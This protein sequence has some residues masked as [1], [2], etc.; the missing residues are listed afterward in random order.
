MAQTDCTWH[1]LCF[2]FQDGVYGVMAWRYADALFQWAWCGPEEVRLAPAPD[3]EFCDVWSYTPIHVTKMPPQLRAKLRAV[4]DCI[5]CAT[6]R[7]Q[8]CTAARTAEKWLK[9]D[10]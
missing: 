4:L 7:C 5:P 3:G 2:D 1:L 6:C 9:R 10:I 8:G